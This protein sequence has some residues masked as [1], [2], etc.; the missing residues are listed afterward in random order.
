[1][2]VTNQM[3]TNNTLSSINKNK[4]T[5][6]KLEE[7]YNSGKK[8]QRPSDDPIVAVRALKLR[9]TLTEINQYLG[10]NI[11]DARSWMER[12]QSAI[13]NVNSILKSMNTYCVQ[14]AQDSLTVNDRNSILQNLTQLKE[15]IYSEGNAEYAGRYVFTGYKTDSTL[16][17]M[18]AREDISYSITQSFSG[19]DVKHMKAVIPAGQNV[20]DPDTTSAAIHETYR[21]QLAYSKC[22]TTAVGNLSNISYTAQDGTNGTIAITKS[23][24]SDD[25]TAY[26]PGDDEVYYL[27]DTGEL[28]LGKDRAK[29]LSDA[30]D[31][32]FSY[33]KSSFAKGELKPE[34]YF[35]CTATYKDQ[36]GNAIKTLAFE[37][38]KQEIT[39][40]VNFSQSIQVNVQGKDV[41]RHNVGRMI[42][43]I[44]TAIS[45]VQKV[46]DQIA[47]IEN[48]LKD[49][50]LSQDKIDEYNAQKEALDV[51]LTLRKSVMQEAFG[52]GITVTQDEQSFVNVAASD[53][54]S[55]INRLDLTEARLEEQQVQFEELKSTNE[56]VDLVET[57]IRYSSAD[58]IYTASLSAA[59][60][61]VKNSLLDFL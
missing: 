35:T 6:S 24:T 41:I 34:D 42:D 27:A 56:D 55:R 46:E 16:T 60:K 25:P 22:D 47:D 45:N 23:I 33:E 10:K 40:E 1:M 21:I 7:Q 49:T 19:S 30:S 51:E 29:T 44:T 39:Y 11:P 28:V 9:T 26:Q 50:T 5:M 48:K 8:I 52:A 61:I 37:P 3:I 31:I 59:A 20:A 54:G 12:S 53:L 43:D 38:K 17:F 15:Q 14:G 58:A 13:D 18:E 36:N 4:V 32:S 2:R 57:I